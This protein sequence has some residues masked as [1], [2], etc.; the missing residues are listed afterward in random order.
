MK[1]RQ[2]VCA[3]EIGDLVRVADVY[4]RAGPGNFRRASIS[5]PTPL[6]STTKNSLKAVFRIFPLGPQ[7]LFPNPIR[8]RVARDPGNNRQ[9]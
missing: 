8:E 2:T 9:G 3:D 5:T 4:R 7:Q 1:Y 6:V